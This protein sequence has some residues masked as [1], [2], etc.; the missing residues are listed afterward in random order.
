MRHCTGSTIRREEAVANHSLAVADQGAVT[1][2]VRAVQRAAL[3][4]DALANT[5]KPASLG[6]L[7]NATGLHKTTVWRLLA[8]LTGQGLARYV[9]E[10]EGYALGARLLALGE[11]ARTQMLPGPVA[12]SVLTKLRD[13]TNET[14]HLAVPDGAAMVYLEKVESRQTVRIA[15]YVG[16]RLRLHSTSLGKAYLAFQPE[17]TLSELLDEIELEP[18]TDRTITDLPELR[19]ELQ[20]TRERGYALDDRENEPEMRCI[21]APV[22]GPDGSALAA[23]SVSAPSSR[24]TMRGVPQAAAAVMDCAAALSSS[25]SGSDAEGRP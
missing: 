4:L 18:V 13:R 6:A 2:P 15:S 5:D 3:I 20:R 25:L 14:T 22:L 17:R 8:T 23:V 10:A 16:A 12:H 21:G 1:Q 9:P 7:S 19:T 24:L 11:Q